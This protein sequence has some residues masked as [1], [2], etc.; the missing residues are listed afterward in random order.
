M[1]KSK[2]LISLDVLRGFDMFWIMGGSSIVISLHTALGSPDLMQPVVQHMHHVQWD[3]FRFYDMIF[4][5]FL[6]ISGVS[7]PYSEQKRA[8][9]GNPYPHIIKRGVTLILLGMVYNGL[10]EL[11]FESV[12]I[13]SVLGRIGIAWAAA[14]IIYINFGKIGR[15][16]WCASL[17]I[18]Y[19]LLLWLCVAPDAPVGASG[20]SYEGNLVGYVDRTLFAN[21]LHVPQLFD[22]EGL[23]S[24]I[25]AIS[26]ALLGMFAGDIVMNANRKT[27]TLLLLGTLLLV[28]GLLWNF[29]MPINKS[30]WSSSFVCFVGGISTLL[31]AL[32]YWVIDVKE[33]SR[34]TLFF[35]VIGLNS[36]TIYMAGQ[37]V[38]FG[39]VSNF[40]FSGLE[41][42]LP[43]EWGALL[44]SIG[45]VAVCWVF[46]WM[47]YRHK[48]F[49]KV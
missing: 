11:N 8:G 12:R 48:I 49:L 46:L 36:I 25:P 27:G 3:G 19:W 43:G 6:F 26:T 10:L 29:V 2:R 4:P 30:L 15:I 13:F 31:F 35:R 41:S 14:A 33:W 39:S 1:E 20:L 9:A 37:I 34:W 40:L 38:D 16:T 44:S 24:A 47:L 22:P 42:K 28:L 32:F 17:L 18:G 21:H 45:Y 23:L 5:L 7:F